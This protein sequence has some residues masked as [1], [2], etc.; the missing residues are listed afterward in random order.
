[1]HE[2]TR[3]AAVVLLA[4][5]G[6]NAATRATTPIVATGSAAR[7]GSGAIT[8]DDTPPVDA[9][10]ALAGS[11]GNVSWIVP[12][13]A[14][15]EIGGTAIDTPEGAAP[16]QIALLERHG[17][18]IRIGV[19]LDHARFALWSDRQWLLGTIIE[20]AEVQGD[21]P[22]FH[23][24][25]DDP[26]EV[27]LEPG[28]HVRRL[29]HRDGSTRV[30]YIGA[31]EVD[32]WVPDK[33]IADGAPAIDPIG[34]MYDG[35][36]TLTVMSGGAIRS[37]PK[38]AA[39][40]LAVMANGYFVDELA[41]VDESWVEVRYH[42]GDVLVHGYYGKHEP[43]ERTH[44]PHAETPIVPVAPNATA[45]SGT[46]LYARAGGDAVGFLVG[47]QRVELSPASDGW[48]SLSIDTPWGPIAF[49]AHGSPGGD[50]V[51][52]APP[53]SVPAAA[54]SPSVP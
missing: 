53:G 43:P 33:A 39:R 48:S 20:P 6:G 4:A 54:S 15:L 26:I 44:K 11:A 7:G 49:A 34:R 29:G 8:D 27:V 40:A 51:A 50:L 19:W 22:E 10:S 21:N 25:S 46:C 24:F 9:L 3:L 17:S 42:D 2:V 16:T 47:D 35:H 5:C 18:E 32:G 41:Q 30:R 14:S 38:W 23:A 12:R 52:C 1:M 31:V 13:T 37:E 28:A 45:A 36:P